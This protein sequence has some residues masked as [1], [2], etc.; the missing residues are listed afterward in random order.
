MLNACSEDATP[1]FDKHASCNIRPDCCTAFHVQRVHPPE[2]HCALVMPSMAS[3]STGWGSILISSPL[4]H[5]TQL[6]STVGH[7]AISMTSLDV[8]TF[9]FGLFQSKK[10]V[11]LMS[12]STKRNT[13]EDQRMRVATQ[14][15]GSWSPPAAGQVV[16]HCPST[17]KR[18]SFLDMKF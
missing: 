7:I 13:G 6:T 18:V 2:K 12:A 9:F 17:Y 15:P 1:T 11:I 8:N 5:H 3:M 10:S 16:A 4:R 14:L